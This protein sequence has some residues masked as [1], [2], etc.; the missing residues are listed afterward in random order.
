MSYNTTVPATGHS[1]SQDYQPMQ[2]N[3]LQ[4]QNS[5]SVNH[6][7]LASGGGTEGYHTQINFPDALGSDPNLVAPA[8][9]VYNKAVTG[10]NQ[11]FF[12]NGNSG[13]N[14]VQ[15]TGPIISATGNDG[16]GGTYQVF[17]TPWAMRIFTGTTAPLSGFKAFT[18]S[19]GVTFGSTIYTSQVSAFGGGAVPASISPNAG[20]G[21]FAIVTGNNIATRWFIMTN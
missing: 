4:I 8:S 19:G 2:Q 1:G 3:F 16:Q 15:L 9:S 5:F 21:T 11:L 13:S 20:A 12:Q 17:Q 6:T 7:P 14:V 18:L 10:T